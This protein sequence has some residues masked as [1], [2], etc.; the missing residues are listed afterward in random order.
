MGNRSTAT[1]FTAPRTTRSLFQLANTLPPLVALWWFMAATAHVSWALTW[2]LALP[3]AGLMMRVFIIQHD[4]GH[5]SFFPSRRANDALGLVLGVL[6]VTPYH[7][8]RRT[9]ALHHRNFGKLEH[10]RDIGYFPTLTVK[11]YVALSPARQRRY[12]LYRHPLVFCGVGGV[13]QF[14]L[15]HRFPW[16][17]P[18][19][20]RAEWRSVALTNA[21]LVLLLGG[22]SLGWGWST[23]WR[24]HLPIL[25]ITGWIGVWLFYVQHVFPDGYL[26]P[27]ADWDVRRASTEGSSYVALPPVARWFSGDIGLHHV[28]HYSPQIPN[29][30][31]EEAR[32]AVPELAAVAPVPVRDLW[33]A[34]DLK[35]WDDEQARFVAFP[36]IAQPHGVAPAMAQE[37]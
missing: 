29:Y 37:S 27:A 2:L 19:T 16:D 22:L 30:R 23:V 18:R 3:A 7:Y 8:W 33:R 6:T 25:V 31:L 28:H 35:L 36:E 17:T 34:W 13:F 11:E 10:R 20:W 12:R 24:V 14:L 1:G 5:G 26:A 32:R 4:C 9:H 15:K 21:G